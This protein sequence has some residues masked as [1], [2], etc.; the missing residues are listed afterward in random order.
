M[1]KLKLLIEPSEESSFVLYEDDGITNNY[2]NG[3]YLKTLVSVKK[4]DGV[5][6]TFE[7]ER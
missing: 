4:T 5:K 6:I 1:I 7:K 3:E 2:K